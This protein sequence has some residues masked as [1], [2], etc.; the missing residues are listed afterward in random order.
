MPGDGEN[1]ESGLA[2]EGLRSSLRLNLNLVPLMTAGLSL[3]SLRR[4][5]MVLPP[6]P[7]YLMVRMDG[8]LEANEEAINLI[9][10]PFSTHQGDRPFSNQVSRSLWMQPLSCW[11]KSADHGLA[12]A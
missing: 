11:Q 8:S 7:Q 5:W 6:P 4:I 3:E 10:A 9:K 1:L 2:W 12:R